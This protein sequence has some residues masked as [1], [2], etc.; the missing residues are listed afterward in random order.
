[1]GERDVDKINKAQKLEQLVWPWGYC[2]EHPGF[3]KREFFE[4][5]ECL[6]HVGCVRLFS[7]RNYGKHICVPNWATGRE[8]GSVNEKYFYYL[9]F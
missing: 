5:A 9:N 4:E 6:L 8:G 2:D 7:K 3:L 1:M